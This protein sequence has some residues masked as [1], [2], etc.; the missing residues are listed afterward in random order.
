MGAQAL[1]LLEKAETWASR[2]QASWRAKVDPLGVYLLFNHT[3]TCGIIPHLGVAADFVNRTNT[4][5]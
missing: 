1:D 2:R 5:K 3:G 4:V